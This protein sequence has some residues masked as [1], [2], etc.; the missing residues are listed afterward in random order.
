[1]I[2]GL[3]AQADRIGKDNLESQLENDRK[4]NRLNYDIPK[5]KLL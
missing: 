5:I 1:M 4:Y 2:P 3:S